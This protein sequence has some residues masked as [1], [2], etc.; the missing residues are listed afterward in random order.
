MSRNDPGVSTWS[1]DGFSLIEA[2]TAVTILAIAIVLSI[3][4]IMSSLR[5]IGDSRVVTVAQ[6]LAQ[7]EIE[8]IRALD[9]ADVGFPGYTPDGVLTPTQ[10]L[11]IE[12]RNYRVDTEV[13]YAGS[14]TGDDVIP[15]GGDGVPGAWD[16][17]VDY[18]YVKVSVS[19][20]GRDADPVVMETIVAPPAIGSHEGIANARVTLAAHEPFGTSEFQLPEAK[21]Q[22]SPSPAIRS[23]TRGADQVFPAI[24]PGD[25]V[26][27]LA[28]PDGWIIHPDDVLDGLDRIT[29]SAGTL[30]TSTVRVYKPGRLLVD[31]TD[32]DTGAAI[33]DARITLTHVPSSATTAH[34]PGEYV[35][36]D[37]IPDAY[38][39]TVEATGYYSYEVTS[40]NVPENYPAMDHE[41]AVV[42]T[43]I[44][45]PTT[46]TTTEAATTTTSEGA[47]TTTTS[48]T[49][50]TTIAGGSQVAVG[51]TVRDNTN[52]P[53]HG[54][55]VEVDHPV[56][57]LLSATTTSSGTAIIDLEE[58]TAFSAAASTQWGHGPSSVE[59][60]PADTTAVVI[61]LTRP[62]GLGTEVLL[63]GNG[64]EFGYR[65]YGG[66]WSIMPS[67][68]DGEASFVGDDGWYQ[69]AKRCL[70]NGDVLGT[71]WLWLSGNSNQA[72]TIWGYC[73]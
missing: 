21:V 42:L 34:D 10:Q 16:P 47:T 66:S 60:D 14:L 18:K 62:W 27:G 31:V 11:A 13:R 73:P 33:A 36:G 24:P 22:S 37:L 29:V 54:A 72:T 17:G 53:I 12:G 64:A 2:L 43:P 65:P 30:A 23:G 69:V 44:P 48:T 71:K 28:V 25:Y 7:A 3:Q 61:T 50:T 39:I 70:A 58:G 9:Y 56:R 51:F 20:E 68:D 5:Q 40:L 49:T 35:I 59:F 63:G 38:D 45:P 8:S 67:N 41:L 26:I 19:M 1:E 55:T 32:A 52:R 15:G 4:P 6:N 46:T 57:G